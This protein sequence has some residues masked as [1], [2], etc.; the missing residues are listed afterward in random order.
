MSSKKTKTLLVWDVDDVLN[1][2]TR[3]YLEYGLPENAR[4]IPYDDLAENPPHRL[5]GLSKEEYLVSLD[6]VRAGDFYDLPPRPEVTAFFAAYGSCFDHV[7]LSAVPLRFME[8]SSAWVLHHFGDWIQSCFFIPSQRP[9]RSVKSQLFSSKSEAVNFFGPR[10]VLIDDS[11]KNVEETLSS[12]G[13][14]LYFPAPWNPAK[15]TGINDFFISLK[16][17]S[18]E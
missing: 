7:V 9:D 10:A 12:G 4:R 6:R 8:K 2:L 3:H 14:A 17:L 15:N 13:R 1:I 5:L 11:V 18:N 16:G